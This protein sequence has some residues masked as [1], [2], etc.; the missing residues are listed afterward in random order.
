MDEETLQF[1]RGNAEAYARRE[2]TSRQARLTAFLDRLAPG[3]S[4]LELGCGAGGD[5]AE[6]L[7]RG[8]AVRPTDGSPEM[9]EVASRR[10]GR[11][12]ETLLFE[13]LDATEAYD[14]VWANACLLHVP[15]P[16]LAGVLARIWR[17]LKP[18]GHFYASYKA[19]DVDGRDTLNRYYNYPSPDWLRATYSEAGRWSGVTIDAGEVK[20]FDDKQAS[21]LFVVAQKSG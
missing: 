3:A 14:A 1:Y 13:Q 16:E 8:F 5:T 4:I 6:I 21:M 2:I 7:S 12:V 19:G 15:R 20:G 18:A 11:P 17:A 10:L 9:A